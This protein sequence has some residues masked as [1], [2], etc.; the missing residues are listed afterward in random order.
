MT[1]KNEKTPEEQ[2]EQLARDLK[3]AWKGTKEDVTWMRDET[4]RQFQEHV[5][6]PA[7]DTINFATYQGQRFYKAAEEVIGRDRM[8]AAGALSAKGGWLGLVLGPK[9]SVAGMII[10]AGVGLAVGRPI[11]NWLKAGKQFSD[12]E[13]PSAD[14]KPKPP[15]P[16]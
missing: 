2:I 8:I 1:Q 15:S 11:N 6:D 12:E 9:G 3:D 14:E 16:Q 10:G 7:R 4:T 13:T 5:S